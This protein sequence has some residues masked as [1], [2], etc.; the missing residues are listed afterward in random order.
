MEIENM[1]QATLYQYNQ[2]SEILIPE[3]RGTTYLGPDNHKP[4]VLYRGLNIEFDFFVRNTDRKPQ[5]LHNKTYQAHILYQGRTVLTKTLINRDYD[6]GILVLKLDHEETLQL[7]VKYYDII[8]TYNDGHTTGNWPGTSDHNMRATYVL[9]VRDALLTVADSETVT[10]FTDNAGTFEG[11]RM[12]GPALTENKHGSQTAQIAFTNY[13]G[14]YKF[15]G[16]LSLQPTASDWFDIPSQSY[17]VSAKTG[18]VYHHFLG[19][20]LYVRLVHTPDPANTGTL[21]KIVYRA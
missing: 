3:R 9:E 12:T 11:G 18:T 13:T 17:T 19:Q 6:N 10:S 16:T 15:Q 2:R 4:L 8:V 5:T 20:Y 1:Y 7:D 14:T 21:D